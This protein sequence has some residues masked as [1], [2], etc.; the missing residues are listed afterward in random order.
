MKP[1]LV[2]CRLLAFALALGVVLMRTAMPEAPA[3]ES[4]LNPRAGISAGLA[5]PVRIE[6]ALGRG[7]AGRP[8]VLRVTAILED[9]WHLFR[10]EEEYGKVSQRVLQY[11]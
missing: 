5:S 8:D 11:V 6:V 1:P 4:G 10:P 2:P 7:E 3:L 9:G